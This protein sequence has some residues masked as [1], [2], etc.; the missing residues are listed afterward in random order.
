MNGR[1]SKLLRK[2]SFTIGRDPKYIKKYYKLMSPAMQK[3]YRDYATRLFEFEK[4]KEVS[5]GQN[6]PSV[7]EIVPS[8]KQRE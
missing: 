4:T 7:S 8:E 6:L 3:S 1:I 5:H 2:V